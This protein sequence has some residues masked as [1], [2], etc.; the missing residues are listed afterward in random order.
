ML[1][2]G[3]DLLVGCSRGF[4]GRY[5]LRLGLDRWCRLRL[6]V[7]SSG[8]LDRGEG[9]AS[10]VRSS[11]YVEPGISFPG[12]GFGGCSKIECTGGRR[13]RWRGRWCPR[14]PGR[15]RVGEANRK[16]NT[17]IASGFRFRETKPVR[18]TKP[19]RARG[20]NAVKV[21]SNLYEGDSNDAANY[22]NADD[23]EN[24]G[25]AE[26]DVEEDVSNIAETIKPD[27]AVERHPILMEPFQNV[28]ENEAERVA[29]AIKPEDE[30]ETVCEVAAISRDKL[31]AKPS[32]SG[33]DVQD[34]VVDDVEELNHDVPG[35]N[36]NVPASG[37]EA[38]NSGL[39]VEQL[40]KEGSLLWEEL[41]IPRKFLRIVV[42]FATKEHF[43]VSESEWIRWAKK[44][45][46][47]MKVNMKGCDVG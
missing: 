28:A 6:D 15:R 24:V 25:D 36:E 10:D 29:G 21:H 45:I 37:N 33:G 43:R 46:V 39:V 23:V 31:V 20:A 22:E 8:R 17:L 35:E 5:R 42:E 26:E 18:A 32:N 3:R 34:I 19:F 12:F 14:R 2:L 11:R 13:R 47:G 9:I 44:N 41:A 4:D 1:S 27:V 16:G 38:D 7:G 40:L 30:Q